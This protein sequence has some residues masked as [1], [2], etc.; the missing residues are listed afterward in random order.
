MLL[1][2]G[3]PSLHDFLDFSCF[4]VFCLLCRSLLVCVVLAVL[5]SVSLAFFCEVLAFVRRGC[6]VLGVPTP[7]N[8]RSLSLFLPFLSHLPPLSLL[9][10]RFPHSALPVFPLYSSFLSRIH[11]CLVEFHCIILVALSL[12][13]AFLFS[14]D[15]FGFSSQFARSFGPYLSASISSF[16]AGLESVHSV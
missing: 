8:T 15:I 6:V 5:F 7:V 10:T 2:H 9:S 11:S 3:A 13:S 14:P 1:L 4:V 16:S 12:I